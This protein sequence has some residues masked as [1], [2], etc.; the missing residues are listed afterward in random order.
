MGIW[1]KIGIF[2]LFLFVFYGG[3]I[4]ARKA[5]S[6]TLGQH[7]VGQS[8]LAQQLFILIGLAIFFGFTWMLSGFFSLWLVL[9]LFVAMELGPLLTGIAWALLGSPQ[10]PW[11]QQLTW[12]GAQL[13]VRHPWLK[14]ILFTTGLLIGIGFPI[15][16]GITY[17]SNTIPSPEGTLAIFRTV[18]VWFLLLGF[19]LGLQ[20]STLTLV[21]ESIHEDTRAR[22]LVNSLSRFL[23]TGLW[24]SL[25]L[26]AFGIPGPG[27]EFLVGG[28]TLTLSP[29]VILALIAFYLAAYIGPYVAGVQRAKT[30]HKSLHE[31]ELGWL[32]SLVEI[33]ELPAKRGDLVESLDR[34]RERIGAESDAFVARRPGLQ[35]ARQVENGELLEN[36]TREETNL[37]KAYRDSREFDPR[38]EYLN[39][40]SKYEKDVQAIITN[41]QDAE[42]EATVKTLAGDYAKA[43]SQRR[44]ALEEQGAKT[45]HSKPTLLLS[46]GVIVGPVA[47][48][49]L[50]QFG[51][52]AI[53]TITG[54]IG[55]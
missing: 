31:K 13:S 40:T 12:E 49:A 15:S 24:V 45:E 32:R 28:V 38:V 47:T 1:A 29:V 26:W 25:T 46:I 9:L 17:F 54:A 44:K 14:W 43:F 53:E 19:F 5:M 42:D 41:L 10:I 48:P 51:K 20:M 36:A 11:S 22:V 8:F 30:L 16:A 23:L 50:N 34:L 27:E 3:M 37:L 18:I 39:A 21:S 7:A 52:W 2:V 35:L 4:A 33:M 55:P 6:Y